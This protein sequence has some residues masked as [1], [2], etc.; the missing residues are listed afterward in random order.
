MCL[1]SGTSFAS[2]IFYSEIP[3]ET[4]VFHYKTNSRQTQSPSVIYF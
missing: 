1:G 3:Y 2:C 4:K